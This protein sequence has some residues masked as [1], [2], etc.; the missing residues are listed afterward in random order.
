ML[1]ETDNQLVVCD[2]SPQVTFLQNHPQ[3]S[4]LFEQTVTY[5]AK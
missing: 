2:R 5:I 4:E 3:Y 1:V